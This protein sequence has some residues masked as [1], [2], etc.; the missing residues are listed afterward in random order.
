MRYCVGFCL[1]AVACSPRATQVSHSGKGAYETALTPFGDGFA[2]AWYDIRDGNGEIYMRLLDADGRFA[3]PERRLTSSPEESFE[4]SID[5]LGEGLAVAWYDQASN[6]DRT[7]K[8]GLWARDG[9]NRWVHT[10]GRGTRNPVIRSHASA[11]FC[12]WVQADND[13]Q[14]AVFGGWWGEDGQPR[15]VPVRLAPASETTWNLN[16]SIDEQGTAWVVFDAE[17]STRASEVYV[18]RADASAARPVRLTKDDGAP[19]K[20]PD[21]SIGADGRVALSWQDERDGNVEVYLLTAQLGDLTGEI[22]G[23]SHRVTDTP[24]E[25][26]GAYLTWNGD[27]L[28]LAWADKTAG[29]HEVYF[30]SFDSSGTSREP[31]RRMTNTSPWSLVP[32]IRPRGSGFAIAWTE[33]VPASVELHAG[34]AE[35]FFQVIP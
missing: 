29:Q 27:R 15:A 3:G 7:V 30:E 13:G 22:D 11:V 4:A 23:R 9:T 35:V 18:A 2:M 12:A 26:N 20:Y 21:L 25:S 19:S 16:T 34:S 24:G 6:G 32:A 31:A 28:G 33:Y 5:R 1:F 10:F 14:E 8:L 17:R